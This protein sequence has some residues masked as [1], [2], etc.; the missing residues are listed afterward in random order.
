[1]MTQTI[2][3]WVEERYAEAGRL[4]EFVHLTRVA[5][6]ARSSADK[7]VAWLHDIVEDDIATLEAVRN[8]LER[9][10]EFSEHDIVALVASVDILMRRKSDDEPYTAYIDRVIESGDDRAIRVK[11]L[12]LLDHLD[13]YH[14]HELRPDQAVKYLAALDAIISRTSQYD[15]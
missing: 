12:D 4:P 15:R 1:M 11:Q 5:R 3:N 8:A 9:S 13:P 7:A 14:R 6:L 2:S 10:S